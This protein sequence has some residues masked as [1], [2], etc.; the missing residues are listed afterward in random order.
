MILIKLIKLNLLENAFQ[1]LKTGNNEK[2][3]HDHF[4]RRNGPLKFLKTCIL[5]RCFFLKNKNSDFVIS[6]TYGQRFLD[7]KFWKT[8]TTLL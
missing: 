8:K 6:E 4:V 3:L 7:L 2:I 5:W 1:P